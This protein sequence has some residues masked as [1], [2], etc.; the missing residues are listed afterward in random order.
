MD[1][2]VHLFLVETQ[3]QGLLSPRHHERSEGSHQLWVIK[4]VVLDEAGCRTVMGMYSHI[5]Y[6]TQS[7]NFYS[8][9]DG[10]SKSTTSC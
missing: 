5:V 8:V 3:N 9:T 2:V 6:N 7:S 1:E 4:S 10:E